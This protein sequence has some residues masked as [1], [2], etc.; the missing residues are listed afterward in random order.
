L[1]EVVVSFLTL[2]GPVAAVSVC[3]AG[4]AEK[5]ENKQRLV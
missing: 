5:K 2:S 3:S 1:I 4:H